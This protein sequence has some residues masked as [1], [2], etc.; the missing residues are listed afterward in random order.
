MQFNSIHDNFCLFTINYITYAIQK[1]Y[2]LNLKI[3]LYS[4]LFTKKILRSMLKIE[5]SFHTKFLDFKKQ[6]K[7]TIAFSFIKRK[8]LICPI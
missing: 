2:S 4:I 5:N 6:C 7:F 1:S 8:K 3:V